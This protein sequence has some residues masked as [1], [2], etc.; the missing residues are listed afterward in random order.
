MK[1]WTKTT[2]RTVSFIDETQKVKSKVEGKNVEPKLKKRLRKDLQNN[3]LLKNYFVF[4]NEDPQ[5]DVFIYKVIQDQ[6]DE[7]IRNQ[8]KVITR[9]KIPVKAMDINNTSSTN[10][11]FHPAN[12]SDILNIAS[13]LS[14]IPLQSVDQLDRTTIASLFGLD[15]TNHETTHLSY[16]NQDNESTFL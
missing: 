11:P 1:N 13:F 8:D 9:H 6:K 4:H 3:K 14:S 10:P 12:H 15:A 2:S 16:C 7:T 5:G